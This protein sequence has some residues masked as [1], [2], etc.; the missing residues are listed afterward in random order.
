MPRVLP[1]AAGP[2]GPAEGGRVEV[3]V[4]AVALQAVALA[5]PTG[6]RVIKCFF[7]TSMMQR[8]NKLVRLPLNTYFIS[9]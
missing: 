8:A 3:A 6:V 5:V 4:P 2:G 9:L 1:A 7:S